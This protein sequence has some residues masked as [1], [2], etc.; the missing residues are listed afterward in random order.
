MNAFVDQFA[1]EVIVVSFGNP[2]T[3]ELP[4]RGRAF[5]EIIHITHA[6]DLRRLRLH[7]ALP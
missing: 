7:A 2:E 1:D 4:G 5:T 3:P 6:V